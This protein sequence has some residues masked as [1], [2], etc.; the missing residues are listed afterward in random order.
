M[1]V[2]RGSPAYDAGLRAGDLVT[3]INSEPVQGLYHTQ[4]LQLLVSGG[5]A[6]TMRA[7]PLETT[8]IKTGGRRRDPSNIK[9]A[10]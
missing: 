5:E 4:V 8:S 10:R 1:E 2:D 3:H 9:M 6:V 7:T